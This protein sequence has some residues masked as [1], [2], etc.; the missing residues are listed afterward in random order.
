MRENKALSER[1]GTGIL[2]YFERRY[3][4]GFNTEGDG[5]LDFLSRNFKL[6]CHNSLNG[7]NVVYN[8]EV[9]S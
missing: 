5:K 9:Y 6:L 7:Y 4:G 3:L 1:R 2:S 8:R